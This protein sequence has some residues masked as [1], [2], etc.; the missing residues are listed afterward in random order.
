VYPFAPDLTTTFCPCPAP[1]A[2]RSADIRGPSCYS[3][4]GR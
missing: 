4:P 3:R 1:P 2:A